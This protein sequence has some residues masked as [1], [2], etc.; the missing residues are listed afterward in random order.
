MKSAVLDKVTLLKL[1]NP[2]AHQ[3]ITA[4]LRKALLPLL[5]LL[6]FV[7][8]WHGTASRIETSLGQFPGPVQV[9]S[10]SV[11]LWKEHQAE[12]VKAKAFFERQEVRNAER[13]KLDP[14]YEAKIRPYTGAPTFFAQ[15]WTSLYTVTVGFLLAS[16]IAVPLG[17]VCGLSKSVYVAINPLIQLFKPVSPLA[18]LPLVTMIVSAVYVTDDRS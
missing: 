7:A 8:I 4:G 10:Q 2:I 5:G 12:Q 18:W 16:I 9:Y 15:I 11:Q 17:I 14:G 6:L 13:S 3:S 1:P